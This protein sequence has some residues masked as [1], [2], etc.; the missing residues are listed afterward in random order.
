MMRGN[1]IAA[2]VAYAAERD[3]SVEVDETTV[4]YWTDQLRGIAA[5]LDA[6]HTAVHTIVRH[7]DRVTPAAV[8]TELLP[9]APQARRRWGTAIVAPNPYE[10]D[11]QREQRR[12]RGLEKARAALAREPLPLEP[13]AAGLTERERRVLRAAADH[14]N[15]QAETQREDP[16]T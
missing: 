7:G 6:A 13:A 16:T 1:D 5:D 15:D 14:R 4:D 10:T 2:L 11:Y 9:L 8:R 3:P 12:L